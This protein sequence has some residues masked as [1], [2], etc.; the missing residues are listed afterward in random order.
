LTH[1]PDPE[2]PIEILGENKY[3]K[4]YRKLCSRDAKLFSSYLAG[5][6]IASRVVQLRNHVSV[7]V[8]NGKTSRWEL[9]D[10]YMNFSVRFNNQNLSALDMHFLYKKN[11]EFNFPTEKMNKSIL[12]TVVIVPKTNF[13]SHESINIFGYD[14]NYFSYDNLAHWKPIKLSDT[15]DRVWR[16]FQ[17]KREVRFSVK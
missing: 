9:H 8:F 12:D 5:F 4:P 10:P 7:E 17:E 15:S 16:E 1:L 3:G 14:L 2:S 6:G 13:A 11:V